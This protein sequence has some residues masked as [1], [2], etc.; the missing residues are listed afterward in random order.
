[1]ARFYGEKREM[2]HWLKNFFYFKKQKLDSTESD[3]LESSQIPESRETLKNTS[4]NLDSKTLDSATSSEQESSK[5]YEATESSEPLESNKDSDKPLDS[6][7]PHKTKDFDKDE[8]KEKQ[9][10][11]FD[12]D[13]TLLDSIDGIYESFSVA[14]ED[15]F[16]PSVDEIKALIGL[17]L[18]DMFRKLGFDKSEIKERV[19]RY[20]N[21][22]RRICMSKTALLPN[23]FEAVVLAHSFAHLGVVTTKTSLYSKQI[24]ESF[25]MLKYFQVVI[26]SE[27]V[28][29][30]K[31]DA[32]PI[33][34]ALDFLPLTPKE[35]VYM[36]GDTIYDLESAKNARVNGIWVKNGFGK[37][38]ESSADAAFENVYEAVEYIKELC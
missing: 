14:C 7:N 32:E 5:T 10:I 19:T 37:D 22:Y 33:L 30:H 9:I 15:R 26:G 23:A 36:I 18:E 31:P 24:L 8:I 4:H 38:L 27:D 12:L 25:R 3:T 11:L 17:P 6:E 21:H 29:A 2:I 1:M 13:G 35:R 20:K 34:K 16:S 28:F